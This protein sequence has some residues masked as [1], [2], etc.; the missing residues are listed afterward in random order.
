MIEKPNKPRLKMVET[1]SEALRRMII[2]GQVAVGDVLRN[3][4]T[5][6]HVSL[7]CIFNT[8]RNKADNLKFVLTWILLFVLQ[9]Q[10][11]ECLVEACINLVEMLVELGVPT[12]ETNRTRCR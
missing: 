10:S 9:H 11:D 7:Q 3:G 2:E 5:L 4:D 1:V 8:I 6:M 12:N